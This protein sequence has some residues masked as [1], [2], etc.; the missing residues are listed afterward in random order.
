[1]EVN[2]MKK[3]KW[4]PIAIIFAAALILFGVGYFG[5]SGSENEAEIPAGTRQMHVAP[6]LPRITLSGTV[7][8]SGRL[9]NDQGKSFE[10]AATDESLEVKALVGRRVSITGAVMEK[11]GRKIV[12]VHEYEILN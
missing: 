4:Y 9:I 2:T 6:R 11:D 12:A 3:H 8:L 10:L 1:M 5:F 7:D